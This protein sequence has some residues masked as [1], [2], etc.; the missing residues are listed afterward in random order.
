MAEDLEQ[1]T[2]PELVAHYNSLVAAAVAAGLQGYRPVQRFADREVAT[3]RCAALA[4]SLKA[5]AEAAAAGPPADEPGVEAYRGA[6]ITR[7]PDG[8]Y[9]GEFDGVVGDEFAS[10]DLVK[11]WVDRSYASMSPARVRLLEAGSEK[12]RQRVL[13]DQRAA[14]ARA[15]REKESEV[16]KKAKKAKA[17]KAT[18]GGEKR[19]RASG[20]FPAGGKIKVLVEENPKREGSMAHKCF[21]LYRDGMT[22][23]EYCEKANKLRD[24]N[25][26]LFLVGYDVEHGYIRVS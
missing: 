11:E 7:Q 16:A 20:K 23:A 24:R 5:R 10:V 14:A 19:G 1:M 25:V 12:M 8:S 17:P 3:R 15:E 4:S 13:A 18:N 26:G 6:K 2:G 21:A 22:V 9:R